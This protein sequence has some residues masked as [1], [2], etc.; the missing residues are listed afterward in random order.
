MVQQRRR[1]RIVATTR[2]LEVLAGRSWSLGSPG[3]G[4]LLACL[5]I[6]MSVVAVASLQLKLRPKEAL[7]KKYN[8]YRNKC[9]M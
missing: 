9:Y 3:S 6:L 2:F 8:K 5:T 1:S 7:I 4:D